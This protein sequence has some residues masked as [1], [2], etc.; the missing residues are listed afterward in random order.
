ML[1][2][3]QMAISVA[4]EDKREEA[5]ALAA[6]L[7][8][9][10]S[11]AV[12]QLAKKHILEYP[13]L[14]AWNTGY[15]QHCGQV[16]VALEAAHNYAPTDR[17][18]MENIVVIASEFAQGLEFYDK[19]DTNLRTVILVTP[20]IEEVLRSSIEIYTAK[21]RSIDPAYQPPVIRKP[22]PPKYQVGSGG[23][24]TIIIS[25]IVILIPLLI[26]FVLS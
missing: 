15:S 3:L 11:V 18:I 2:I 25:S 4:P 20:E 8:N 22:T 26:G 23:C 24:L 14:E 13:S 7:I 17:Q 12:F 9:R 6:D 5:K 19:F 21:I 16:L 10:V 1:S